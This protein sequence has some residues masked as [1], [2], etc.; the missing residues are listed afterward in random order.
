MADT[1]TQLSAKRD[2]VRAALGQYQDNLNAAVAAFTAAKDGL[3][4]MS[5]TYGPWATE[6]DDLA[7]A[8]PLN[9]AIQALKAEKDQY[10]AE[11]NTSKTRA[12]A[13]ETAV[14]GK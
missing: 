1:F 10:V 11:F 3:T 8:N 4:Q 5:L 7:L 9:T 6:I 2:R 14:V 13:L 12:S